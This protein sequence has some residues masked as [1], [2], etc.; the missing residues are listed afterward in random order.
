MVMTDINIATLKAT[1]SQVLRR[2]RRGER[3][4]V[5]DRREPVAELGPVAAGDGSAEERL[6][7]AGRLRAPRRRPADVRLTPLRRDIRVG[8]LLDETREDAR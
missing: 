1:L 8:E 4:R 3:F 7:A 2:V 6:V 5:L